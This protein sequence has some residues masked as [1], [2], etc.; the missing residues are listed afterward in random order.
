MCP[1]E[2]ETFFEL[3]AA[4]ARDGAIEVG[5]F[6]GG[7]TLAM[8][9]AN[10]NIPIISI[11]IS[12]Q[13][14]EV[15]KQVFTKLN[16]GRNVNLAIGDSRKTVVKNQDGSD[17]KFDF[18]FIDGDHSRSGCLADIS[19]WWPRLST[20]GIMVLHDCYASQ[21]KESCEST[22]GVL[23]ATLEFLRENK[24]TVLIDP[25]FS[26]RPWEKINGSLFVAMKN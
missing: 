24:C 5:R 12:P 16:V 21:D 9:M 18:L 8:A 15:L 7:S 26:G 25:T 17:F 3:F 1:W 11:D 4:H 2:T 23:E 22:Q 14:D 10:G 13:N 6:N 20:G 19:A